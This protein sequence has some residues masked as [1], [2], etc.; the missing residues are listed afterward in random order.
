MGETREPIPNRNPNP[1]EEEISPSARLLFETLTAKGKGKGKGKGKEGVVDGDDDD[2]ESALS[3]TGIPPTHDIIH[4]VLKLCYAHPSAGITFFRWAGRTHKLT[5]YAWNLMVDI[6]GKNRLFNPMWDAIRSMRHDSSLSTPTFVSVFESYCLAGNPSDAVMTFDV[7]DKYGVP[8]DVLALNSLLSSICLLGGGGGGSTAT[9]MNVF[10]KTKLKIPPNA[11][12]FT[13]LLEG[14]EKERNVARAKTTIGEMAVC[15]GWK[16]EYA[17]AYDSFLTT[18][19]VGLQPQEAVKFLNFMKGKNCF[20][21]LKFFSNALHT[22]VKQNDAA[23]AIE[24]W[25]VMV[26]GGGTGSGLLP[27]LI[28]YNAMIGLLC[29]NNH[30]DKALSLLDEM[31]FNGAFP[32]SSTY[33]V[34]FRCLISNKK[35]RLVGSFFWEMVKNEC[36]PSHRDCCRAIALLFDG[37][38]PE[39][40]IDIWNYLVENC[41]FEFPLDDCANALL[42]G[43]LNLN[44][45]TQVWRF[46]EDMLDRRVNIYKST[47]EKLKNAFHKEGRRDRFDRLLMRWK[48]PP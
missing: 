40:A 39:M 3:S 7:M 45:L 5:P 2:V 33:A 26:G 22:L 11:D 6:L 30:I 4:E 18:L 20:P 27:N 23:H 17:P 16:P 29:N 47:M 8:Q 35:V 34:I 43:L 19:V 13:I 36:P 21:G 37:D 10:E 38:D 32:D 25:D 41:T 14:W 9:A 24:I 28:M 42:I 44:R 15:L 31:P 48:H 46:A 12:T 1:G